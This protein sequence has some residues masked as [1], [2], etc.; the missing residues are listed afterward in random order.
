MI[1]A[2]MWLIWMIVWSIAYWKTP[3]EFAQEVGANDSLITELS[4]ACKETSHYEHC[5]GIGLA[6]SN[7]ETGMGKYKSSHW[8][9]WRKASKDKSAY[10]FAWTYER[11]YSIPS[12]YNEWWMFYGYWPNEPAPTR[13]CMNEDSS[14]SKWY[15]PNGRKHF[16]AIYS[17]YRKE[18]LGDYAIAPPLSDKIAEPV[19]NEPKLKLT[20][21][22][23]ILLTRTKNDNSVIQIDTPAGRFFN[24]IFWVPNNS[25]VF[26]CNK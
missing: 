18:V 13:Y 10:W 25:K 1:I 12:K 4:N 23:C 19:A 3:V 9:F 15:C 26:E 22:K 8:F 11:K 17:K 16:N 7:T 2:S 6:I 24:W 5:F 20:G 14:N 21:R